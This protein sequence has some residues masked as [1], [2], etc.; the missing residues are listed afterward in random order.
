MERLPRRAATKGDDR[1]RRVVHPPVPPTRSSARLSTHPLLRLSGQLPSCRKARS[2]PPAIGNSLLH[3]AAPACRLSRLFSGAHC[4][5]LQTVPALWHG[6]LDLHPDPVAVSWV[7]FCARRQLM[8][9]P[10]GNSQPPQRCL[11]GRAHSRCV[12]R[13][14]ATP[15]ALIRRATFS[16]DPPPSAI[17]TSLRPPI[18]PQ[19]R[20]QPPHHPVASTAIPH[21]IAEQNPLKSHPRSAV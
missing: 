6:N 10:G 16:S 12:Q 7:R 8:M 1:L 4:Q 9:L 18:L 13:R 19:L 3:A 21:L 14:S 11:P 17:H 5:P 15:A 2:M 20:R